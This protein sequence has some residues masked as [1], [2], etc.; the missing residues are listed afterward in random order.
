MQSPRIRPKDSGMPRC[1]Q[2]S[3]MAPTSPLEVLHTT[4]G[5]PSRTVPFKLLGGSSSLVQAGYQNPKS[6]APLEGVVSV[7]RSK[8]VSLDDYICQV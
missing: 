4:I 7:S 6:G 8:W 2:I 3:R 5:S 1:G